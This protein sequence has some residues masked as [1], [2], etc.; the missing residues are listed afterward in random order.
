MN[1]LTRS[2]G[3]VLRLTRGGRLAEA[4]AMIQRSLADRVATNANSWTIGN[5]PGV[6]GSGTSRLGRIV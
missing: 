1:D 2:M 6:S 4:T 5:R 3:D